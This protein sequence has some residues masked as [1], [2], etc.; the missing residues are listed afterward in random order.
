M[1]KWWATTRLHVWWTKLLACASKDTYCLGQ[2]PV[3]GEEQRMEGRT[4]R[5]NDR[6]CEMQARRISRDKAK[7]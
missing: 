6:G 3:Q 5:A 2:G 4:R 7:R 1:I